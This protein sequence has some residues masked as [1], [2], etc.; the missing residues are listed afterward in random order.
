LR[1]NEDRVK[2]VVF[3]SDDVTTL[4]EAL[5]AAL[6]EDYRVYGVGETE[7]FQQATAASVIALGRDGEEGLNLHFADLIVHAD[8]PLDVGRMEQRIGR[9]DRFGRTKG[10]IR[11][12][13]ITPSGDDE[14]PWSTWLHWLR[15]GLGIFD[16]SASDIQ[17]VLEAVEADLADALLT[18]T[19]AE[20][21]ASTTSLAERIAAERQKLDEQYALDQLSLAPES[22]RELIEIIEDGE[23]DEAALADEVGGLLRLLQFGGHM[24][25]DTFRLSWARD[26]LIPEIPWR[27]IFESALRKPLTWRRRI[28]QSNPEV[29]LLRPGSALIEALDRFLEWDDRG[30]A[31]ATWRA[32]PGFGGPGEERVAL[33]LCWQVTPRDLAGS[34]LQASD[35]MASLRRQARTALPPWTLV[36]FL[37]LSLNT[38]EDPG[39]LEVLA[40]AYRKE[41]IDSGGRDYNLGSRQSWLWSVIDPSVFSLVCGAVR[42]EGRARV[43]ASDLYRQRI[44]VAE[45]SVV[46]AEE[47]RKRREAVSGGTGGSPPE[48]RFEDLLESVRNPDIRLES[49]GVFVVS[50]TTPRNLRP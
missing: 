47:R 48:G 49:I 38:I 7:A 18:G 10:P 22:A 9:L 6:S 32:R 30:T 46:R 17:F 20:D 19:S 8:L 43:A 41:A 29:A 24:T 25:A 12:L 2:I 39:L 14:T 16:R 31:F 4:I 36:Q 3:T 44:E 28:A 33:K 35:E 26:T 37:D 13:I 5:T 50:G 11:H 42:E 27:P 1:A 15:Y 23:A 40:E 34:G 21:E 45:E